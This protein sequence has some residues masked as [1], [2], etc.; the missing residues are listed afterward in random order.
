[1][2]VVA[3]QPPWYRRILR[4][5]R[6]VLAAG[7]RPLGLGDHG[8]PRRT[9]G[10]TVLRIALLVALLSPVL[11]YVAVPPLRD[12]VNGTLHDLRL[13]FVPSLVGVAPT[14]IRGPSS[15]GN[16]PL[17]AID[18]NL[19]SFWA[20]DAAARPVLVLTFDPPVDL[21]Q[22]IING[23]AS[24]DEETDFRRPRTLI[25]RARDATQTLEL[26]NT[27]AEQR[28]DL[29]LRDVRRLEIEVSNSFEVAG[30][31]PSVAIRHL[32]FVGRE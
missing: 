30:S 15:G 12:Q 9:L 3:K 5:D 25:L 8:R 6:K 32:Q 28:L 29:D 26:E 13:R 19:N 21:A 18:T 10:G 24:A 16:E 22:L 20:A 31:G 27:P 7:E 4:R 11:A 17:D 14:D 1:M 23:G 2:A